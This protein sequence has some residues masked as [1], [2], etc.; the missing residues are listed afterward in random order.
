M[1]LCIGTELVILA[2]FSEV[3]SEEIIPKY[4]RPIDSSYTC[5]W[6]IMASHACVIKSKVL[7]CKYLYFYHHIASLPR[8][9]P[10]WACWLTLTAGLTSALCL[11]FYPLCPPSKVELQ[12]EL[13]VIFSSQSVQWWAGLVMRSCFSPV[14]FDAGGSVT[15]HHSWPWGH[16]L[17]NKTIVVSISNHM[18]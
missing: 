2:T 18:L 10:H 3:I 14:C 15:S 1:M 9:E 17:L 6:N 7:L 12:K 16:N 13:C 11:S 4:L 5:W 8:S